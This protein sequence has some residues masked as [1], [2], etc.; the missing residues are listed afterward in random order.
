MIFFEEEEV[1]EEGGASR[2]RNFLELY[3][4]DVLVLYPKPKQMNKKQK[5]NSK[6]SGLYNEVTYS[7]LFS[8]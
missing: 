8:A 4:F 5:S 1:E 2:D 3:S 6:I 7:L